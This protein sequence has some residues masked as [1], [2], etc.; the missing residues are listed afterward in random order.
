[1]L[2]RFSQAKVERI[3]PNAPAHPSTQ[4]GWSAVG[5]RR[6]LARR[7]ALAFALV[8]GA[9]AAAPPPP[10]VIRTA[11]SELALAVGG[12]GRLYE[13]GFGAIRPRAALRGPPAR[14][15]EFHPPGGNGYLLEP[16][17]AAVHA[18]GNTSTELAYAGHTAGPDPAR[19]GGDVVVTRIQLRDPAYPF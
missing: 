17:L 9:F 13:L 14:E 15:D 18:D 16:A 1:M 11:H 5:T 6:T 10:I 8:T 3:V 2:R 7:C 12:D 19:P 4:R